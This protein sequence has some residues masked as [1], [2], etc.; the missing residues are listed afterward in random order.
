L[1][2]GLTIFDVTPGKQKFERPEP[3]RQWG[4][5]SAPRKRIIA[6]H[7]AQRVARHVGLF[8]RERT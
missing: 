8:A 3:W 4:E 2:G 5:A 7:I 1:Q 6:A